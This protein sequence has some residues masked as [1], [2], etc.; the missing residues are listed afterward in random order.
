MNIF[1]T[2]DLHLGHKNIIEYCGRPHKSLEHMNKE[3]IRRWNERVKEE[4]MIFVLGDFCFRNSPGGKDGE[5]ATVKAIDYIWQLKGQK[6]F[7]KGNHDKNNS[8]KTPIDSLV[9][10]YG[11]E[12]IYCCHRPEDADLTYKYCFVGHVHGMW[13]FKYINLCLL[14]NVGVDRWSFYPIKFHEIMREIS[15]WKKQGGRDE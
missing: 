1:F 15:H 9:I 8:L 3:L 13:T 7:L 11:G 10:K 6:I 2:S 12:E 4:D 5:G 14:V